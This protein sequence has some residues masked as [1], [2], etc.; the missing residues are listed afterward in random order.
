MKLTAPPGSSSKSIEVSLVSTELGEAG[1]RQRQAEPAKQGRSGTPTYLWLVE[2]FSCQGAW[3]DPQ[4]H[5]RG[6]HAHAHTHKPARPDTLSSQLQL[7]MKTGQAPEDSDS[8]VETR[9]KC[10]DTPLCEAQSPW[11]LCPAICI[12]KWQLIK[13]TLAAP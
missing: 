6:T 4:M 10:R 7:Q 3:W 5:N 8:C 13:N 1:T 12:S 11:H 9:T 2:V